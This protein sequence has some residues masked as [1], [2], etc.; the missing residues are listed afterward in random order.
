MPW[1]NRGGGASGGN[2]GGPWGSPG[3]RGP[4][5]PNLEDLLRQGQDRFRRML[6]RGTGGVRGVLVLALILAAVW[7][8][9]GF[10]RVLPDEQGVVLRFGA[11]QAT[12]VPGL[13]YHL[14]AP[15]ETV[16][17]PKVTTV[18]REEVGFRATDGSA[19]ATRS[20]PEEALML[21]GDENIIEI[22]FT[23]FWRIKDAGAYLF[24]IEAPDS[25]VKA[26]AEAAMREVIGQTTLVSAQTE[27][28]LQI[29][30][31]TRE[32]LQQILDDYGA[33]IEITEINLQKSDPPAAVLDAYRDVQRARADMERLRNEA[34]AYAND[35]VPRARGEAEQ[36]IQA[37]EAYREQ[38]VAE[39]EGDAQRF[40]SVYREY[41]QAREVTMRRIYIETMELVLGGANKVIV[42]QTGGSGVIPYLPLPE[43]QRGARGEAQQ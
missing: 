18:H 11:L 35:V 10:Y 20:V 6:P 29:E 12:T 39:A 14:P 37:A 38:V 2:G 21:T 33:G 15:I 3:P 23:V 19:A 16:E 13:H 41:A 22:N 5:P 26:A 43:L 28:R 40:L 1:N 32:R 24:N 4:Q 34:E 27:G 9:S 30:V 7:C 42:D 8:V 31:S 25:T 17:T 36:M